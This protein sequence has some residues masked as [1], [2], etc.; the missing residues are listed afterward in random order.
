MM[1]AQKAAEYYK[2]LENMRREAMQRA[3]SKFIHFMKSRGILNEWQDSMKLN[4]NEVAKIL[5]LVP[6]Q[7]EQTPEEAPA[8][9]TEE[10]TQVS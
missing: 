2:K 10:P 3:D 6:E 5:G 9:T 1:D 8:A 7:Q 4:A